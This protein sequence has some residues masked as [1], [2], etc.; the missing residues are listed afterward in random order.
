MI[1]ACIK[2]G[3][4]HV[5]VSGEH[6]Y[7]ETMELKYDQEAMAKNVYIISACGFGSIPADLGTVF[8]EK[9]FTGVINSVETYLEISSS[10]ESSSGASYSYGA[11][12]SAV[13]WQT[14]TSEL[15]RLKSEL[16][17]PELPKFSPKLRAKLPFQRSPENRFCLPFMG[18]DKF[19]VA[20]TQ[21]KLFDTQQK[22]PIQI[23]TYV[24]IQ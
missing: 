12:E 20:R 16:N 4:H 6:Q 13:T 17:R 21:R 23:Q 9:N 18:C 3:S 7:M 10:G 11:W 8:M 22:R 24:A 5:D 1:E 15:K 14:H 2:A 19:V